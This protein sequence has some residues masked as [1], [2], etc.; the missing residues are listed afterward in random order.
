MLQDIKNQIFQYSYC[1]SGELLLSIGPSLL[2][3]SLGRYK[4]DG[5]LIRAMKDDVSLKIVFA[6]GRHRC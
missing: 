4:L 5:A 6:F 3:R 2:L 1:Y